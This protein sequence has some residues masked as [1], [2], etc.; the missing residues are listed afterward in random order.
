MRKRD[1]D[2][3]RIVTR[4]KGRDLIGFLVEIHT[5][6]V[7]D[8]VKDLA[9]QETVQVLPCVGLAHLFEVHVE[10]PLGAGGQITGSHIGP[11]RR[12]QSDK[13]ETQKDTSDEHGSVLGKFV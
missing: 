1:N 11:K 5:G 3:Q 8:L 10:I 4:R 6:F 9:L 12:R 7:T 13:Q 2:N